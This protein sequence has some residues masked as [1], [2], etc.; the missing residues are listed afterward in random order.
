MSQYHLRIKEMPADQQPRE[1]LRDYGSMSLSD[2]ELL[3]ILLRVGVVGTNV[4]ELARQLLEEFGGWA[5]MQRATYH[6]LVD[7][8]GMGEAKTAQVL[9]AL[10][11]GRRLAQTSSEAR[12]LIRSPE[13]AARLMQVEM[14]HLDQEHLRTICLDVKNRLLKVHTVY[15]GCLNSS[16]VRVGEVFKEAIKVNCAAMLVVHNHPSGD[17]T[18]SP[19]DVIVTRDIVKAGTLLDIEVLDHLIIG[20]GRWVSMREKGLG[21]PD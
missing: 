17:P 7:W 16:Y 4:V 2:P 21:F 1:R 10:E 12:L 11:I 19:D 9:A 18:P 6:E 13:D 20:R 14:S 3:A 8:H 15:I 5:G